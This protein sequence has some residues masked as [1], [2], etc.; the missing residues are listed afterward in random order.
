MSWTSMR[1]AARLTPRTKVVFFCNPHNPGGTVWSGDEIQGGWPAVC[2][3]RN[4]ILV[5]DEIQLRSRVRRREAHADAHRRARH[6]GSPD[7]VASPRP[8]PSISPAP[9]SAA[10]VTSNAAF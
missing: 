3:E 7:H 1:C 6:R 10:C 2:A 5:S 8:R 4:L 9:M